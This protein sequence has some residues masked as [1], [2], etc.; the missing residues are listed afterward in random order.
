[1]SSGTAWTTATDV[2]QGHAGSS[3]HQNTE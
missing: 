1:V 2:V 3:Q